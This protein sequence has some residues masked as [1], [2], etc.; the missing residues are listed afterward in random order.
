M[1]ITTTI[2]VIGILAGLFILSFFFQKRFG[3]LGLALAAGTLLASQLTP[4]MQDLTQAV[5]QYL[6]GI[7]PVAAAAIILTV[8]P[9]IILM[10]TKQKKY[11]SL[12]G[13]ILGAI[14][15]TV[16]TGFAILPFVI[17]SVEV[18]NEIKSFILTSQTTAI[19][20]GV[21]IAL[22]DLTLFGKK[23]GIEDKK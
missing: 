21:I 13:R 3:L 4:W 19:I 12:K 15:Y 18:S 23:S 16:M 17:D 6:G 20:T 5:Q 11:H 2:I 14:L 1:V 10:L 7:S 8:L 22:L 9:S